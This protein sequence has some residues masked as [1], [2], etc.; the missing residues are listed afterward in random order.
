M[1]A[2]DSQ[3]PV[4]WFGRVSRRSALA[5]PCLAAWGL[6]AG[7]GLVAADATRGKPE[8]VLDLVGGV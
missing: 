6:F 8:C 4:I 2:V 3:D 7:P 5:I 1:V